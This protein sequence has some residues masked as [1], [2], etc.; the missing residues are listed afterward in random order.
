MRRR[1]NLPQAALHGSSHYDLPIVLRWFSA[2]IGV[3]HVHHLA[4]R[5]PFYRLRE[6]LRDFP[7]FA[8]VGRLT[9]WQSL[10]CVG[11]ALW[12]EDTHG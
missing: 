4:S 11:Y 3:H 7:E 6:V 10:R 2:N 12:D 9:L 8:N 5:I 1:W